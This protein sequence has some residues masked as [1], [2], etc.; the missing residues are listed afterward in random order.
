M[1]C[2]Y[3]LIIARAPLMVN[4]PWRNCLRTMAL[5]SMFLSPLAF[6]AEMIRERVGYAYAAGSETLLYT[7]HHQEWWKSGRI[8]RDTVTY[9][10]VQG[11]IIGEKHLDFRI[12]ES[13]PKFLLRNIRTGHAE[14]ATTD[15][16]TIEVGFR[17]SQSAPLMKEALELPEGA[18]VDAGFD[19]FVE[20]NWE[21]LIQGDTFVQP[22]LVPS[23]LQF[24]D[25][26]I[27]RVDDGSDPERVTFQMVTNSALLRLFAPAISVVYSKHDRTLLQ[28]DGVSNMRNARGENLDVEIHFDPSRQLVTSASSPIQ[29]LSLKN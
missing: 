19:R 17:L 8:L 25:F 18:I 24:I 3:R 2:R 4:A 20:N 10:D 6:S 13:A 12:R 11:G 1:S 7:E 16:S 26:R 14:G 22:F 9:R 29:E 23:R 15:S 21:A 5:L 27:R 28:Y